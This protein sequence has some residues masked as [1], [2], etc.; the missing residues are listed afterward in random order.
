MENSQQKSRQTWRGLIIGH[1]FSI[2]IVIFF[3]LVVNEEK[4]EN[5][6]DKSE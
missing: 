3:E 4:W 5:K 1:F 6:D 2:F